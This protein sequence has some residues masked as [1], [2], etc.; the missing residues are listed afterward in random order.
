M[1]NNTD[2]NLSYRSSMVAIQISKDSMTSPGYLSI[3]CCWS[4]GFRKF[5][6]D[7]VENKMEKSGS[8]TFVS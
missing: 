3:F 5:T 7:L 1:D 4:V 8:T 6:V 2:S